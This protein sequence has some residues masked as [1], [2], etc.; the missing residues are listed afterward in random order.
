MR[1]HTHFT[2]EET[3]VQ[4]V[5]RLTKHTAE[6]EQEP[7]SADAWRCSGVLTCTARRSPQ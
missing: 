4:K 5:L 7:L 1:C 2:D 3:K 6:V